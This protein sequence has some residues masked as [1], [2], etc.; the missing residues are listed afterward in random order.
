VMKMSK[1]L[2]ISA[3]FG[4]LLLAVAAAADVGED[5]RQNQKARFLSSTSITGYAAAVSANDFM[6]LQFEGI[7]SE[8]QPRQIQP[9]PYLNRRTTQSWRPP[10]RFTVNDLMKERFLRGGTT[11][12]DRRTNELVPLDP[13]VYETGVLY[14]R[15]WQQI[16]P[17]D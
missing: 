1:Q 15:Y 9:N 16:L 6:K 5:F 7:R 17:Q 4:A 2:I 14:T 8:P 11:S 10:P 3:I 12:T 13:K